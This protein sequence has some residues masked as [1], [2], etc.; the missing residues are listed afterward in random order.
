[1]A[2]ILTNIV[3]NRKRHL[4]DI[5]ARVAHVDFATLRNSERSLYDSLSRPGTSFIMECKSA[6]PSLGPIRDDYKPG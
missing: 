2:K 5:R 6:S 3:E 4:D 1:M